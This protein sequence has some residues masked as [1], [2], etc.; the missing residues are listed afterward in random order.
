MGETSRVG[1]SASKVVALIGTLFLFYES[2]LTFF[3]QETFP[4]ILIPILL[5]ILGIVLGIFVFISL[6]IFQTTKFIIPY[7][8]WLLLIIGIGIALLFFFYVGPFLG[9][10]LIAIAGFVEALSDDQKYKSSKVVGLIGAL[11]TIIFNAAP[12]IVGAQDA[13]VIVWSVINIILA[14]ILLLTMQKKITINIPYAWWVVLIIGFVIFMFPN[15][16]TNYGGAIILVSFILVL[17]AY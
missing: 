6:N 9:G 10:L 13:F 3:S 17:M 4:Q 14:V 15:G 12:S 2:Y 16:Y 7:K 8:S 11:W 5:G 1:I